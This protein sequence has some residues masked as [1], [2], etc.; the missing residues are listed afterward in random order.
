MKKIT[1]IV[2]LSVICFLSL[3]SF[4]LYKG[5]LKAYKS[6]FKAYINLNKQHLP[7]VKYSILKSEL[8]VNTNLIQW[9]DENKEIV[10][11][12]K[13]YDIISKTSTNN[14]IVLDLL[15]DT[16]EYELKKEFANSFDVEHS[17]SNSPIKLL[18]QFLSLKCI[19]N[20]TTTWNALYLNQLPKANSS[21]Q[22]IIPKIIVL[23]Q[24]PPPNFSC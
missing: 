11:E 1:I 4:L 24:T 14:T 20:Y 23:V 18:K 7:L 21:L 3:G 15:E 5:Y 17:K 2:T 13:L 9:E 19:T 22:F 6:D 16:K 8:Y 10:I 12:G